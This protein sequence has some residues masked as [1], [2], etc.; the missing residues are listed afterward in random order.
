MPSVRLN[1]TLQEDWVAQPD[2][3]SQWSHCAVAPLYCF[4]MNVAGISPLE[5]G[6]RRCEIRPQ[7]GDLENL[8]LTAHTVRG[9]IHFRSQGPLGQRELTMTLPVGCE[10]ELV[11]PVREQLEL[12]MPGGPRNGLSRYRL[13]TGTS[14]HLT[15]RKT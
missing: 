11:L 13:P 7:L 14:V 5:P 12:P 15:L 3:G 2:S 10:G 6:F 4:F 8:D 9:P 1:N